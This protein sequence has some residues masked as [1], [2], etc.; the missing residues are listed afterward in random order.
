MA[1]KRKNKP[2]NIDEPTEQLDNATLLR[3]WQSEMPVGGLI[4]PLDFQIAAPERLKNRVMFTM[5]IG[6]VIGIALLLL[7]QNWLVLLAIPLICL[8]M[9]LLPIYPMFLKAG[10]YYVRVD[11]QYQIYGCIA[12]G[13]IR[14]IRAIDCILFLRKGVFQFSVDFSELK[15]ISTVGRVQ[16]D[17]VGG[18]YFFYRPSLLN[19]RGID[20]EEQQFRW[21]VIL[22]E[23]MGEIRES[24]LHSVRDAICT[25]LAELE[26]DTT[27]WTAAVVGLKGF[28]QRFIDK[29]RSTLGFSAGEFTLNGE[30][31][32]MLVNARNKK[33][34][35]DDLA[36]AK[37]A[38]VFVLFNKLGIQPTEENVLRYLLI[39]RATNRVRSTGNQLL[40][41]NQNQKS[42]AGNNI[43]ISKPDKP[44]LPDSNPSLFL[45][46]GNTDH[47]PKSTNESIVESIPVDED[48]QKKGLFKMP[49]GKRKLDN[50]RVEIDH[51]SNNHDNDDIPPITGDVSKP[52]P[53]EPFGPF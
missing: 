28:V 40:G 30:Y 49:W 36:E 26:D 52:K 18:G 11:F 46:A 21:N 25:H 24:F 29:H 7:I 16:I 19:L 45:G 12:G 15:R 5:I 50:E 3:S 27:L 1:T 33:L 53:K 51:D 20:F 48:T 22:R 13:R 4:S 44:T 42:N 32:G 37:H 34:S 43:I 14:F 31:P 41:S 2:H 35:A 10:A 23:S 38:E 6:L 17:L 39:S 9:P 8:A 47:T